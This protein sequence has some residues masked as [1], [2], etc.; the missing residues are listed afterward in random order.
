MKIKFTILFILASIFSFSQD[1]QSMKNEAAKM[2]DANVKL[3]YDEI[4]DFTYPKVFD[5]ISKEELK[6]I[7][8]DAFNNKDFNIQIEDINPNFSNSEIKKVD[9]KSFILLQHDFSFQLK[10][11]KDIHENSSE[12][13]ELFKDAMNANEATYSEATNTIHIKKR[14]DI[15]AIADKLTNFKWKFINLEKDQTLLKM[16]LDQTILEKLGL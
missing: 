10:F 8:F 13:V 1:I 9:G 14:Q 11:K 5:F 4:I 7:F 3:N 2:Y 15:L 6:K 16:I 12:L